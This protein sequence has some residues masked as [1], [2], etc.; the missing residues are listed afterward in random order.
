[1]KILH[2]ADI[3]VK[4]RNNDL[5]LP[6][7]KCLID[8]EQ[9]LV[10]ENID[11]YVASGDFWEFGNTGNIS[12]SERKLI[13]NHFARCLN[14]DSLKE[15]V[16]IAGNHDILTDKKET[17][18]VGKNN[19]LTVFDEI[20]KSLEFG[21]KL[22]YFKY[23]GIYNSIFPEIEYY[24][25]SLEDGFMD[26]SKSINP[27]KKTICLWHGMLKE[28]VDS[29]NLPLRSD[30][31]N[32][33]ET[34]ENFPE[35]SLILA[36]DIHKRLKFKG[37]KNQIFVYPGSPIQHSHSEGTYITISDSV[38]KNLGEPKAVSIYDSI[39][40]EQKE[41]P[42][43]SYVEYIT[44]VL[45]YKIPIEIIL[46]NLKS[47]NSFPH[48]DYTQIKVKSSNIF[49]SYEKQIRE[50]LSEKFTDNYQLSFDYEKFIQNTYQDNTVV[51]S[52]IEE[53]SAELRE[54]NLSE[55]NDGIVTSENVDNL[56]LN[57]EQ[58]LK[59]FEA[60]LNPLLS[61]LKNEFSKDITLEILEND[62]KALFQEELT[63]V[64]E[65]GSRRYNIKFNS[66]YCSGFALLGTN[67]INLDIPGIVRIL[68]TNGIGKTTLFNL[69]RWIITGDIFPNMS[70]VT[71]M[72]NN[73]L[74]F[75]NRKPETNIVDTRLHFNINGINCEIHRWVERKWKNN[76]TTEQ[77][78]SEG[79]EE[80]VST[81]DR[82][83]ELI[84][85]KKEPQTLIG[86]QAQ[87][88]LDM[89][90]G[91]VVN[92]IMILNQ[93]KLE[94]LLKSSPEVL[95]ELILDFIG[96]DYLK[97]LEVSL[98]EV[99]T[100]LMS[101]QKPTRKKEEIFEA[102]TDQKIF[103]KKNLEEITILNDEL[104]NIS[105]DIK[106]KTELK[107]SKSKEL[108]SFGDIPELINKTNS[109]LAKVNNNLNNFTPK[110]LLSSK[111]ITMS[112]PE[113]DQKTID[114]Y[115]LK[116]DEYL[117]I[118][119]EL[120]EKL[121]NYSKEKE[122]IIKK[123]EIFKSNKIDEINQ[124]MDSCNDNVINIETNI[125]EQYNLGLNV[126]DE[127]IQKIQE[128]LENL[129]LQKNQII[130]DKNNN[131]TRLREIAK[132]IESGICEACKRPF[133]DDFEEHKNHLKTEEKTL[134]E[135][136]DTL[137]T[138]K[139]NLQEKI[140]KLTNLKNDFNKYRDFAIS[141]KYDLFGLN[142][143][144]INEIKNKIDSL[145]EDIFSQ[146]EKISNY[147]K[148][149]EKLNFVDKLFYM[150][151]PCATE[152]EQKAIYQDLLGYIINLNEISKSET[153][154]IE[155]QKGNL[156]EIEKIDS[157][158]DEI[159]NIYQKELE[160]YQTHIE[161]INEFNSK[162]IE[163]NKLIESHNSQKVA[164]D[165]DKIRITSEL[166]VLEN[167]LPKYNEIYQEFNNLKTELEELND[168]FNQKNEDIN[169][170]K[171]KDKTYDQI[172]E[173]LDTEYN[174]LI[175]YT[176]NQIIWKLYSKIIQS[177]YKE[178]VFDYYR[179]YLNNTLNYLLSDVSFKLFWN[180]NSELL[181][182]NIKDG[183]QSITKVQLASGM[184]ISFMALSLV[185]TMHVL[186][187]KN[188]VSHIFVDE[189]SGTLNSGKELSY[190]ASDYTE[191]FVKILNKFKD[192]SIFIVDH[193]INSIFET[194]CYEVLPHING[195]IYD[196][197]V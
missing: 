152:E 37:T 22:K 94:G 172:I 3:Q 180:R 45:D 19:P 97:K 75:N 186:N 50:I 25:N 161:E 63:K 48:G 132:E 91:K 188:A 155:T 123:C 105:D 184:E 28:Y 167:N 128:K 55:E 125:K 70:K 66:V 9:L 87:K 88:T 53:K 16:V 8:I 173:L 18:T 54:T 137:D 122:S 194:A 15:I 2:T 10:S 30:I 60:V 156:N 154:L 52:I 177:N 14:I 159:K 131:I 107:D 57:N 126:C 26:L 33:L 118:N 190:Q 20:I 134:Q 42:L 114:N 11:V 130:T 124:L 127:Y 13:Y 4:T 165:A 187:V 120:I 1:M 110:E 175:K 135:T 140:D 12:E 34:I 67:T 109:E 36:G 32:K 153:T 56:I 121:N 179:T 111:S 71:Q 6:S 149:L 38:I 192:K 21:D 148:E 95:N 193:H 170:R 46:Q 108:I 99:K 35:N 82:N 169:T 31:Y 136:N 163:E 181:F 39:N 72:R 147:Q 40:F 47:Y 90:F 78:V 65:A 166:K 146:K 86:E 197:K 77:K 83:I 162:I 5:Y 80:F 96:V 168:D 145:H 85:H 106:T 74:V 7:N 133:A 103:K 141:N 171:I 24:V 143:P 176:K 58:L 195:S 117:K 23:S 150:L 68:G 61:A 27:N 139:N 44:I 17:E 43:N 41:L 102:Q 29:E 49:L 196:L 69:M 157:N 73:L 79:W 151:P 183:I 138:N 51:T 64:L 84:I 191:L 115:N 93:Q 101:I 112:K 144:A 142:L 178:I 119:D 113:L 98:D 158:I 182:S 76:T 189:I 104:K 185:Y 160:K 59:L 129:I 174:N 92:N 116:K 100:Q 164:W 62:I 89:W 81:V